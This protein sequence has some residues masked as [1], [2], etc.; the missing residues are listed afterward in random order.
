MRASVNPTMWSA[1]AFRCRG[2]P[3]S[4]EQH[5]GNRP[6]S[7]TGDERLHELGAVRQLKHDAFV[8]S[9]VQFPCEVRGD[10][11]RVGG[12]FGVGEFGVR[13]DEC[14]TVGCLFGVFVDHLVERRIVPVSLLDVGLLTVSIERNISGQRCWVRIFLLRHRYIPYYG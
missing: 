4:G 14:G 3:V 5:D 10:V 1:S 7:G 2:I 12:E 8:R 13:P 9:N 11:F 6:D